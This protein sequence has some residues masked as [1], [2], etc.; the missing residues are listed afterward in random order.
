MTIDQ[1]LKNLLEQDNPL[2]IIVVGIVL[3]LYFISKMKESDVEKADKDFFLRIVNNEND[4]EF[5]KWRKLKNN[6]LESIREHNVHK[7][8]VDRDDLIKITSEYEKVKSEVEEIIKE[9]DEI[10]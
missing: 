10:K 8:L 7:F 3:A 4:E 6:Y 2:I 9:D 1:I 5:Q